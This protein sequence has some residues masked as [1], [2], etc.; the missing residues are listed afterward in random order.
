M[1]EAERLAEILEDEKQPSD[2]SQVEAAA[3]LR[4]LSAIEQQRTWV[5]LTDEEIGEIACST[6]FGISPHDD[7]LRFA[8]AIT[9]TLKEKNT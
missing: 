7:T 2:K 1:T 6:Q 4:R 5:G 9:A 8:Y 3:E